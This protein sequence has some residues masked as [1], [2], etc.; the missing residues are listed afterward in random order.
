MSFHL[1]L[2]TI[3]YKPVNI[4]ANCQS[5][6]INNH[7]LLSKKHSL[8]EN[9]K[10][11]MALIHRIAVLS[12]LCTSTTI[13][14]VNVSAFTPTFLSQKPTTVPTRFTSFKPSRKHAAL[15]LAIDNYDDDDE[16]EEDEDLSAYEQNAASEF[17][18][19]PSSSSITPSFSQ[20]VDWGGEYDTLRS[21]LTDTES[22]NIG[23]SRAL[24]R[25]MTAETPNE[26]IMNF[27]SGASPEVVTAMSAAVTSLLG[28]LMSPSG[29]V[30]T[31]VKANG[32]KL[33]SLCFQ[34]QM[35]GYMVSKN[36]LDR[37]I[38]CLKEGIA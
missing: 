21:R 13:N 31:I 16:D 35:T 24:F 1:E 25:T 37:S 18:S 11:I 28:G 7:Q 15:H 4:T 29:G 17:L 34:L 27:V 22:G 9:R 20:P 36:Q 23:P 6:I 2:S 26:A 38:L 14:N 5:S 30:Q 32:E 10:Y 12:L 8:L 33:G 19:N 3:N